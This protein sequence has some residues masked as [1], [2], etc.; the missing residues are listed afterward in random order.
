MDHHLARR[1]S[2]PLVA[3]LIVIIYVKV[4]GGNAPNGQD[5]TLKPFV[6]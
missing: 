6:P 3:I 5:F 2:V 1:R 4:I